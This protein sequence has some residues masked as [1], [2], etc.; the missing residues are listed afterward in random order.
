MD[1]SRLE[2]NFK[3][4]GTLGR[5]GSLF[6]WNVEVSRVYN[7][8]IIFILD[9]F[10]RVFHIDKTS[11]LNVKCVASLSVHQGRS[12]EDLSSINFIPSKISYCRHM[13][14]DIFL[15]FF[16]HTMFRFRNRFLIRHTGVFSFRRSRRSFLSRIFRF[17]ALFFVLF[18]SSFL[19]SSSSFFFFSSQ[20]FFFSSLHIPVILS[21]SHIP[22][23]SHSV[24]PFLEVI[25]IS[26]LDS[27]R[28]AKQ[29]ELIM[30][31]RLHR[32][33]H[34]HQRSTRPSSQ[35][36]TPRYNREVLTTLSVPVKSDSFI[37]IIL[38]SK[39]HFFFS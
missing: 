9:D 34:Q 20:F 24:I 19:I 11:I 21:L 7:G 18:L 22:Y 15:R 10:T 39:E 2:L 35:M 28:F 13:Q 8:H 36:S 30:R 5:N 32:F 26:L 33:E 14:S 37:T 29:I 27:L 17:L 23:I 12:K 25:F 6:G 3:A 4:F 16:N 31:N 38:Y 1:F